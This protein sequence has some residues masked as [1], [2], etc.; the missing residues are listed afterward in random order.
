MRMDAGRRH[1]AP[2]LAPTSGLPLIKSVP[3][4]GWRPER[5]KANVDV[6][7]GMSEA[8]RKRRVKWGVEL[9]IQWMRKDGGAELIPGTLRIHG[10]F[11]HFAPRGNDTQYGDNGAHREVARSLVTD[12]NNGKEDYVIEAQFRCREVIQEIPTSLAQ[13]LFANPAHE[14]SIKPLRD[15]EWRRTGARTWSPN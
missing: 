15:R 7:I 5:R 11:P 12:T 2:M 8:Q 9:F 4:L 10:P 1:A 14:S 6:E 13:E 3:S